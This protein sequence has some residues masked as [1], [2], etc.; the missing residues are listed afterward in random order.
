MREFPGSPVVRTQHSHCWGLSS[1]PSWET[2][3]P[4]GVANFFFFKEWTKSLLL[5]VKL[6]CDSTYRLD[7]MCC[8]PW[9]LV[10]SKCLIRYLQNQC[11]S[12]FP[13]ISIKMFYCYITIAHNLSLPTT[14][15]PTF[16]SLLAQDLSSNLLIP[17]FPVQCLLYV[18][19][20]RKVSW[21]SGHMWYVRGS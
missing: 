10:F 8:V 20:G 1:I 17:S 2:K 18:C 6:S 7:L 15:K 3:I 12:S 9:K 21:P 14:G 19:K 11:D 4:R 5:T 13:H 16:F